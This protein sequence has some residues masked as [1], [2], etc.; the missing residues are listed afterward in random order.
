MS[1]PAL[2]LVCFAV[3]EEGQYFKPRSP[4]NAEV[5]I[6][7]MGQHNARK[8][9]GAALEHSRPGLVLSCGFAGALKPELKSGEIVFSADPNSGVGAALV[10]A[11]GKL[12]KFYCA[13]RVATTAQEKQVLRQTTGADVVDMESEAICA[14]CREA[15]IP[16][17]IVRVIL[18]RAEEDLPLDFNALMRADQSMNFP[19][20]LLMLIKSPGKIGALLRLQQQSK[21]AAQRLASALAVTVG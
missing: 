1:N 15:Q 13:D 5:L 2:T 21:A 8:T 16:C 4:A 12:S 17:A 11:G 9:L 6:T 7:G 10:G 20:L 3:K 14:V 18:D 19:K